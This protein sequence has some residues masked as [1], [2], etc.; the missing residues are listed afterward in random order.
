[1]LQSL[2]IKNIALIDN[3]TIDLSTGFNVL[4][5]ETG[6]GKSLII[7]SLALL[8][9][10]KA[11]KSLIS[12]GENFASVEAVFET[13]SCAI[14]DKLEEFGLDRENTIVIFRKL[15]N[16]GK[17]ECRVN[18]KTFTLS[19]LKALTAPLMDLHG[20]FQHQEILKTSNQLKTLDDFGGSEIKIAK[21]KYKTLYHK[22]NSIKKELASF[23]FDS[24]DRE[25]LIDLYSYQ[26]NEIEEA[27]FKDGEEES[28]KEFRVRVLNQEKIALSLERVNSYFEGAG[29]N[30][31]ILG[32]IKKADVEIADVLK[33]LPEASE[34]AER[35]NSA[36]YEI[37]DIA[38]TVE[39]LKDG[40]EFD[41]YSAIENEKRLDLLTSLKKK[42]GA[43]IAEINEYLEKIKKDYEK[44][45]NS[46]EVIEKLEKEK[47]E[48]SNMLFECAKH[49]S[50][51]RRKTA[52]DFTQ[53]VKNELA[54]LS[55]KGSKFEIDFS[56]VT[57]EMA[58]ETGFDKI[59]F[60]FT[61]NSG[62]PLRPLNKVASGGEMSRFMLAVKN[63]TAD[64]DNVDTMIF[65]EIDTGISGDTA[66]VLARKLAKIGKKHQVVCVTHLAQVA[67]FGA[68]HYYIS[69]AENNGV[70]RTSLKVL[71]YE[72][73][74]RE[75]ARIIGGAISD[76]SINH[77]KLMLD[78]GINADLD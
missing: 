19:M 16:D 45:L 42:Y 18:G 71:D 78:A 21:E 28:L 75:I 3:L 29:E 25:K 12:Y 76:F 4:T 32:L 47:L 31:G 41:E 63:I 77:A 70:T 57:E 60:M 74:V 36:R 35:L 66:N 15:S 61:A 24:R 27:N 58:D 48:V 62:Q 33:Y 37:Q 59:E 26:I 54:E 50:N 11:D 44:L 39:S 64:I 2:T 72:N 13:N 17:N 43:N 46:A 65:D 67:S 51:L 68:S 53:K 8:L 52:E 22:L 6:A 55:M 5:G 69:K 30:Y 34:L 56:F 40:L 20:Q 7:D 38:E 1:M 10:E 73:R 23:N 14:L 49:L 9:G